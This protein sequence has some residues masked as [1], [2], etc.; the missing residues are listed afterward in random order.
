MCNEQNTNVVIDFLYFFDFLLYR[1]TL[2][3][4]AKYA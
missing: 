1:A 3:S 2:N 4:G